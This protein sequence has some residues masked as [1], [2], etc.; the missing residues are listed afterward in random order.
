M[1]TITNLMGLIIGGCLSD[2]ISDFKETLALVDQAWQHCM[3][4]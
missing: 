3:W 2:V 4:L 1:R